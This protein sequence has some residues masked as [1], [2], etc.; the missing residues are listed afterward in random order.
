MTDAYHG[1]TGLALAAG[2]EQ[3]AAAFLAADTE[4]VRVPFNDVPALEAVLSEPAAAVILETVP[5]DCRL[6]APCP[7]VSAGGPRGL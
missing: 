1:H 2:D 7:R 6:P 3:A 4:F 5:G